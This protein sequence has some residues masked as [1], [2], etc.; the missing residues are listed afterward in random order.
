MGKCS[1]RTKVTLRS[2]D[3]TVYC[4]GDG[5]IHI[6]VDTPDL[7]GELVLPDSNE[8]FT[9]AES[10]MRGFDHIEGI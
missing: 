3:Y 10:V 2:D 5:H 9:F 1:K 4:C 7:K 6:I 8:A